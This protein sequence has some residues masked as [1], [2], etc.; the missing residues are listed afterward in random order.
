MPVGT[1]F[2][3]PDTV[4]VAVVNYPAPVL[5]TRAA[6]LENCRNLAHYI[7]AAKRGYPGLDLIAF[8][9]YSTQG[10]HPDRWRELTA[11]CPG[12]ETDI[13]AEACRR[14]RVWGVFSL[15]GEHNPA[16]NPFNTCVVI[17]ANGDIA[18]KYRKLVPWCPLEPWFPG[19]RT[20]VAVGPKGL[21]IAPIICYD[22]DQPEI[23]RDVVAKGAELVVRIQGYMYPNREQQ[24]MVA[25]V[26]ALD[27]L[28]YVA[29][30]NLAGRDL[31]YSY[32]GDSC[33][34]D[35][36]GRLLAAC[37]SAPGEV[38]Y[39][40]L[41][42]SAIRDAR[43]HWRSENHSFNLLHRGYTAVPGGVAE[44]PLDF[45]RL[46]VGDPARARA[47]VEGPGWPNQ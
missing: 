14:N 3:S 42:I 34:V 18:L 24:R 19:D 17:D 9:E 39:A 45:Y 43:R 40:L 27:N 20:A 37:G 31:Q 47:L 6:V 15:T 10:F 35:F 8:P 26:R 7:G 22:G 5:E 33:I 25:Q 30:A 23:V 1:V 4:G 44:C 16:G 11:D 2:S 21:R 29:V 36:D 12:P 41:S 13:F 32:F 28:S 46:W 38:Q